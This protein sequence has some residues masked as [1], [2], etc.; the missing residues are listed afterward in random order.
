MQNR[1]YQNMKA[2]L[3]H[4]NTAQG[5]EELKNAEHQPEWIIQ[6]PLVPQPAAA[7]FDNDVFDEREANFHNRVPVNAE[8]IHA[9]QNEKQNKKDSDSSD[10]SSDAF[11]LYED[12]DIL[13]KH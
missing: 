10:T 12:K 9:L 5:L 3:K 6:V 1:S 2:Y 11:V 13:L 7:T 4:I 8:I